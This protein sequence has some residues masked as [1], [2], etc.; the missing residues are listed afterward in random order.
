MEHQGNKIAGD[1]ALF[2]VFTVGY[3]ANAFSAETQN[4]CRIGR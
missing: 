4:I 1:E 3:D 2:F